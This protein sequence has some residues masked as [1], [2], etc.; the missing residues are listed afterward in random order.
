MTANILLIDD[1]IAR[2]GYIP[3]ADDSVWQQ[4][5]DRVLS[6]YGPQLHYRCVGIAQSYDPMG[7]FSTVFPDNLTTPLRHIKYVELLVT[8]SELSQQLV[9]WLHSLGVP[10]QRVWQTADE[11]DTGA[12]RI[13]GYAD[14]NDSRNDSTCVT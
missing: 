1:F 11:D 12:L 5:I 7:R 10:T 14:P 13:F 3:L 6:L 2:K 8:E 9:D 4:I